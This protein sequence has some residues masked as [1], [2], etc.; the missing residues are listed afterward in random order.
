MMEMVDPVSRIDAGSLK[1]DHG[2]RN[3][4]EQG[5]E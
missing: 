3:R 2:A 4:T 5:E 1:K